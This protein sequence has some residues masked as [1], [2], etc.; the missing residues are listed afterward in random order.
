MPFTVN[1]ILVRIYLLSAYSGFLFLKIA[2]RPEWT[3]IHSNLEH[4]LIEK[5]F[6]NTFDNKFIKFSHQTTIFH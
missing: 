6:P 2:D 5:K 3:I 4:V 1:E